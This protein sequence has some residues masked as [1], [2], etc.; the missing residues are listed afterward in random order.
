LRWDAQLRCLEEFDATFSRASNAFYT[1]RHGV[2]QLASPN[3]PRFQESNLG[4]G[5]LLQDNFAN[6][7][8]PSVPVSGNIGWTEVAP[9]AGCSV[10]WSTEEEWP[11]YAAQGSAKVV[12]PKDTSGYKVSFSIPNSGTSAD[13]SERHGFL[14]YIRGSCRLTVKTTTGAQVV[15]HSS[16][17]LHKFDDGWEA[18][19]YTWSKTDA[20]TTH[21]VEL[22]FQQQPWEQ[23]VYLG[24]MYGYTQNANSDNSEPTWTNATSQVIDSM[25]WDGCVLPT[26]A[27]MYSVTGIIKPGLS[28]RFSVGA[29]STSWQ[30]S[31]SGSGT[32][33][34]YAG[35]DTTQLRLGTEWTA[36]EGEPFW[37]A[38]R[39]KDAHSFSGVADRGITIFYRRKGG[40]LQSFQEIDANH[41]SI[42]VDPLFV[43]G[44]ANNFA[45][46]VLLQHQRWDGRA[47]SNDEAELHSRMM[48]D[49]AFRD[50]FLLTQGRQYLIS[51]INM[52]HRR[53]AWDQMVG[54]ISLIEVYRH[55]DW[56]LIA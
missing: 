7:C 32:L 10:A 21:T 3:V 18:V 8:S 9:V 20:A 2:L 46:Y 54:T 15:T 55:A 25:R 6:R 27:A 49:D 1:D 23:I 43:S 28:A 12:V 42:D 31:I 36:H 17:E 22:E 26:N 41:G 35:G 14:F 56:A 53:G 40:Q 29:F 47:W 45:D 33:T 16:S 39:V 34:V 24:G 11:F 44:P 37:A 50:I 38:V 51:E 30:F 4:P 5:V 13:G 48:L 52:A 19:W